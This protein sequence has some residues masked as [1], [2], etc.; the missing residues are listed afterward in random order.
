MPWVTLHQWNLCQHQQPIHP[1]P[2]S[3]ITPWKEVI[4]RPIYALCKYMH[5][6]LKP[7]SHSSCLYIHRRSL[8]PPALPSSPPA[9]LLA[10]ALLQC[11]L[12]HPRASEISWHPP[13]FLPEHYPQWALGVRS[14]V[15]RP[16]QRTW[17]LLC[18][19]LCSQK[20]QWEY[21]PH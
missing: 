1:S 13:P 17:V 9:P 4:S 20:P 21:F 11:S 3:S 15:C 12:L 18:C 7:I 8:L 16:W 5:T 2:S 6:F 19:S 10:P 14:C